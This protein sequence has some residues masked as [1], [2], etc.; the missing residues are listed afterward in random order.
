M[1]TAGYADTPPPMRVAFDDRASLNVARV[2][3]HTVEATPPTTVSKATAC[4]PRP[5]TATSR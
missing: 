4:W 2:T 1:H 3:D 5:A